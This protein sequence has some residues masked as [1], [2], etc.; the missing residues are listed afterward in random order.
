MY[1]I[2]QAVGIFSRRVHQFIQN[3]WFAFWVI[4]DKKGSTSSDCL[5]CKLIATSNNEHICFNTNIRVS[6][7]E[8]SQYLK[9]YYIWWPLHK[10]CEGGVDTILMEVGVGC[11]GLIGRAHTQVFVIH[12]L[13]LIPSSLVQL[14]YF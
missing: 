9:D 2:L 13:I 8:I 3:V 1:H 4:C 11:E 12:C 6:I 14:V 7:P 5:L 10:Q